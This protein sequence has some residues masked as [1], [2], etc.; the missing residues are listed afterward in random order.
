[1]EMGRPSK[2]I[3]DMA[4]GV[5]LRNMPGRKIA[6]PAQ[7]GRSHHGQSPEATDRDGATHPLRDSCAITDLY[8]IEP[9]GGPGGSRQE[10]R[11]SRKMGLTSPL[12]RPLT[13]S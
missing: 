1:M 5:P 8:H 7:A 11:P 2:A 9:T 3:D 6:R 4:Q 10:K 13:L 12:Q